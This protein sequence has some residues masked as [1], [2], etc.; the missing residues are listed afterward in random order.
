MTDKV[1]TEDD[2]KG[3]ITDHTQS[4]DGVQLSDEELDVAAKN[5]IKGKGYVTFSKD[6]KPLI[7]DKE[8]AY[9]KLIQWIKSI[10]SKFIKN[11]NG[12]NG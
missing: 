1:A 2:L 9:N 4:V 7:E 8:E 6:E 11:E 10:K 12:K 5:W 3:I